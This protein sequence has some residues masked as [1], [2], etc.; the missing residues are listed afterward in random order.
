MPRKGQVK[1]RNGSG[2]GRALALP[3]PEDPFVTEDGQVIEPD[4]DEL[5]PDAGEKRM[6]KMGMAPDARMFRAVNKRVMR[7]LS[8]NAGT[9][10]GVSVVFGY[11]L[12][13]ISDV[14][15]C[16]VLDIAPSV[17]KGIREHKA[18][19]ELFDATF[20]EFVNT[21]SDLLASRIAAYAHNAV[22]RVG[23]LVDNAKKQEVQL[24]AAK[25]V[26]D[27]AGARPAD[28]QKSNNMQMNELRIVISEGDKE[29]KVDLNL[30]R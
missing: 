5:P 3:R 10:N 12:L 1:M 29:I 23:H 30:G 24:S 26:L 6:A 22:T 4:T 17:L 25:D 8:G 9:M 18:Y 19:T 14:E 27:R 15:I 28:L 16:E 11:T 13:G 20:N 21:N 2:K 7:E